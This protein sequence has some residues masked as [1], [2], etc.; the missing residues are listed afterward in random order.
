MER[1]VLDYGPDNTGTNNTK[2]AINAAI[3]DGNR[4]FEDCGSTTVRPALIYFPPGTYKICTPII[5]YYFTQFVGDPNNRPIIK[6]CETFTGIALMDVNP[7]IPGSDSQ[8][9]LRPLVDARCYRREWIAP[10]TNWYSLAASTHIGIF[11]ENGSGGFV[12]DLVSEGGAIGWRVSSQ[13]YTATSLQFKNCSTAVDIVWDRGFNWHKIEIDGGSVGFNISGIDGLNDQ[14]IGSV[15][16][17]D[18][19]VKNVPIG[20]LA[21]PRAADAVLDNTI[22]TNVCIIMV[23]SGTKDPIIEGTSGT[24]ELTLRECGKQYIH[25]QGRSSMGQS[26]D[27]RPRPAPLRDGMANCLLV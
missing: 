20:I 27:D 16:I 23:L 18:S 21:A 24:K 7:Y 22:F 1:N 14:G 10:G 5:Q 4:G 26:I 25:N 9:R 11:T 15:S 8:F 6:G 19:V 12:S 13:Q 2:E 17:I 3:M